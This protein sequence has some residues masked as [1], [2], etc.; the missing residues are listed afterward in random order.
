MHYQSDLKLKRATER[1]LEII[2]EAMNR[3]MKVSPE[4]NIAHS[5]KI[6]DFRNRLI[7]GY[8]AVSDEIVWSVVKLHLPQLKEDILYLLARNDL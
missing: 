3:I 8:D 2:G 1:N 7:H 5:R 4:L 6:I